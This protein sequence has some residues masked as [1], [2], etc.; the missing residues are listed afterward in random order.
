[1]MLRRKSRPGSRAGTLADDDIRVAHACASWLMAYPDEALMGKLDTI[2]TLA[3]TL[4]RRLAEP[5]R[6]TVAAMSGADLIGLAERYVDTFDTRRRG[7]LY[8]TYYSSGDTRRR[9]MALVHI[10]QT[11]LRAGLKTET[12]EL[13]DHLTVVLEFS[14]GTSLESGLELLGQNRAGLEL[15]RT[16]LESVDSAWQGAVE[17]VCAT[18]PQMTAAELEAMMTLAAD[19]PAEELVGLDG[20]GA[21]DTYDSIYPAS[22]PGPTFCSSAQDPQSKKSNPV[23]V[24]IRR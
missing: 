23:P 13:P 16:H 8:L 3:S 19:G 11:Y 14:A 6:Q 2:E 18:L 17:A 4:P 21:G 20:Y 15:L 7:C 12:D 9:G 1:M 10:R 22:R 24:E 5:L